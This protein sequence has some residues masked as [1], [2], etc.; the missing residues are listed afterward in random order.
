MNLQLCRSR[1]LSRVL[2][3]LICFTL[4]SVALAVDYVYTGTGTIS[5]IQAVDASYVDIAGFDYTKINNVGIVIGAPGG[6]STRIYTL[7]PDVPETPVDDP[8]TG[9]YSNGDATMT[10]GTGANEF[11]A[12]GFT[13]NNAVAV[14]DDRPAN[15]ECLGLPIHDVFGFGGSS[16][17]T[18]TGPS[19]LSVDSGTGP[20]SGCDLVN[21]SQKGTAV[22]LASI[23]TVPGAL[24]S[25]ALPS[26]LTLSAFNASKL[27]SL[28]MIDTD[29]N[30]RYKIE[31][32][33]DTFNVT[34]DPPVPVPLLGNFSLVLLGGCLAL[35][36]AVVVHRMTRSERSG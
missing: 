10:L 3:L 15:A 12:T 21:P 34:L 33:I 18:Q 28:D 31:V 6:A 16:P 26:S 13:L 36:G 5:K 11:T 29:V 2:V 19:F 22:F 17:T 24:T 1:A 30:Q 27:V 25:T 7:E 4:P 35:G 8:T 20:P 9:L 23:F 32:T 14:L